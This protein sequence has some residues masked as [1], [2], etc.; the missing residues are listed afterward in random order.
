MKINGIPKRTPFSLYIIKVV[1]TLHRHVTLMLPVLLSAT[2]EDMNE[3]QQQYPEF[4]IIILLFEEIFFIKI[5]KLI[6]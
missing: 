4:T 1:Y 5:N 2:H 6:R 3:K